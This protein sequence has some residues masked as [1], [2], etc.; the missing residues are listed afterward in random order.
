[1]EKEDLSYEPKF[2]S[3]RLIWS[4][5]YNKVGLLVNVKGTDDSNAQYYV[6]FWGGATDVS[7]HVSQLRKITLEEFSWYQDPTWTG[8]PSFWSIK[9]GNHKG[10]WVLLRELG[11]GVA[12]TIMLGGLMGSVIWVIHLIQNILYFR[13]KNDYEVWG[14]VSTGLLVLGTGGLVV[15]EEGW[16]GLLVY[17]TLLGLSV[18]QIVGFHRNFNDKQF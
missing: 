12:L 9:I 14:W 15:K 10:W 1:M 18:I 2:K 5:K 3:N 11:M 17:L 16:W 4:K 7:H 8:K 6:K 13:R